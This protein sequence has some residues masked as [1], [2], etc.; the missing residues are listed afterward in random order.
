MIIP[1]W[2]LTDELHAA[3]DA[4]AGQQGAPDFEVIVVVNGADPQVMATATD[5]R[6]RPRVIPLAVNLGFGIACNIGAASATGDFLLFLN[7]DTVVREDWLAQMVTAAQAW[8]QAGVVISLLVDHEGLV[9]EAGARMLRQAVPQSFGGGLSMDQARS[10]GLLKPR[11][12]CYG[13]GAAMLVR[14][15]VWA[16]V[17]GF[18]EAYAPAYYEDV[19]LQFRI[20]ELG[21]QV[22][23]QPAAVVMHHNSRSTADKMLFRE[24]ASTHSRALF[25]Q[26]WADV[27]ADAP[28][29]DSPEAD[30]DADAGASGVD[31]SGADADAG[32]AVLTADAVGVDVLETDAP[33]GGSVASQAMPLAYQVLPLPRRDRPAVHNATVSSDDL[34]VLRA[35]ARLSQAYTAW[36]EA[37]ALTWQADH[38][39]AEVRLSQVLAELEAQRLHWNHLLVQCEQ[40]LAAS[41]KVQARTAARLDSVLTSTSWRVT[42]PL[43]WVTS[44]L[45]RLWGGAQVSDAADGPVGLSD[46]V[47]SGAPAAAIAGVG[48]ADRAGTAGLAG[49]SHAVEPA[50]IAGESGPD[51]GAGQ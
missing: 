26:R 8:D 43:R 15:D 2:R 38:H 49:D 32:E 29:A 1:A 24:Y 3:L 6:L 34:T 35:A 27:L 19:D 39:T 51:G 9:R 44:R 16:R 7:D 33:D 48:S 36:L 17:G 11:P 18:D 22:W 42:V 25:Q 14:A 47:G 13:T 4:L 45:R 50:G 31:A 30:A 10:Q 21:Y 37:R 23:C 28:E 46:S 41:Q 20:R 40:Q 12:L 5:H